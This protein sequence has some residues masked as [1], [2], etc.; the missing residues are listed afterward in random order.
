MVALV[1][2]GDAGDGPEFAQDS[3]SV[4][5]C[6]SSPGEVS[7]SVT[8]SNPDGTQTCQGRYRYDSAVTCSYTNDP[9]CGACTLWNSCADVVAKTDITNYYDEFEFCFYD[10]EFRRVLC[11][12][13]LNAA[14]TWCEGKRSARVSY[15]NG[16]S[17]KTVTS[18]S[19]SLTLMS[20]SPPEYRCRV[21]VNYNQTTYSRREEC[22]CET[23]P[24]CDLMCG[25]QQRYSAPGLSGDEVVALPDALDPATF[26]PAD[27]P[28]YAG[29]AAEIACTTGE[30]IPDTEFQS[31]FGVVY[32]AFSDP[33]IATPDVEDIYVRQ[34]KLLAEYGALDANDY[35]LARELFRDY[36]GVEPVCGD[37]FTD[38]EP[39]CDPDLTWRYSMCARLSGAHVSDQWAQA[40]QDACVRDFIRR[41]ETHLGDAV[42]PA[43][44]FVDS[45]YIMHRA[46][47]EGSS[48]RVLDAGYDTD[49]AGWISTAGAA[50][51]ALHHDWY[52][53]L[54]DLDQSGLPEPVIEHARL[55][56]ELTNN[57]ATFWHHA[58]DAAALDVARDQALSTGDQQAL[59]QALVSRDGLGVELD[60]RVLEAA[61]ATVSIPSETSASV[62]PAATIP[63]GIELEVPVQISDVGSIRG[64]VVSVD[65]DDDRQSDLRV[66][67]RHPS[68]KIVTLHQL[69][70]GPESTLQATYIVHGYDGTASAGSWSLLVRDEVL[71]KG[72][73]DGLLSSFTLEVTGTELGRPVA[74]ETFLAV[75]G[76]S[77]AATIDRMHGLNTYHDFACAVEDCVANPPASKLATL[78]RAMSTLDE[79]QSLASISSGMTD[80]GFSEWGATLGVVAQDDYVNAQLSALANDELGMPYQDALDGPADAWPAPVRRVV[81]ALRTAKEHIANFDGS[82]QFSGDN[83]Q[84][85]QTAVHVS[86][87]T[88]I[89][90][91][92][93][94]KAFGAAGLDNRNQ[95]Y[96]SDILA[97]VDRVVQDLGADTNLTAALDREQA[98]A[99]EYDD[100]AARRAAHVVAAGDAGNHEA[101]LLAALESVDGV[102]D[103]TSYFQVSSVAGSPLLLSGA[104][105]AWTPGAG[106]ITSFAASGAIAVDKDMLLSL[107]TSGTWA[108][109]CSLAAVQTLTPD[110]SSFGP[111]SFPISGGVPNPETGPE[112][113]ALQAAGNSFQAYNY[114]STETSTDT[115]SV[116]FQVC[117]GGGMFGISAQACAGYGHQWS[118][119]DSSS[120]SS[121][122][123]ARLSATFSGGL[124]LANTPFPVGAVGSL[125]AVELP[126]GATDLSQVRDV[127]LVRTGNTVVRVA[128]DSDV[129]LVVNDMACNDQD[130][131]HQLNVVGAILA[132]EHDIAKNMLGRI[133]YT[134]LEVASYRDQLVSTR[135]ILSTELGAIRS[136]ALL[137]VISSEATG[138]PANDNVCFPQVPVS[139]YPEALRVIFD[140]FLDKE[141]LRL[142]RA[143]RIANID[144]ELRILRDQLATVSAEIVNAERT[145]ALITLL[146]SWHMRSLREDYLR[147][148]AL[149]LTRAIQ[150]YFLPVFSLW[151]PQSLSNLRVNNTSTLDNLTGVDLN[152]SLNVAVDD[153]LD[154]TVVLLD[155]YDDAAINGDSSNPEL[156]NVIVSLNAAPPDC[157]PLFCDPAG[158]TVN[159]RRL[160][161][162]IT[163]PIWDTLELGGGV[164]LPIGPDDIYQDGSASGQIACNRQMPVLHHM[165]LMV[166]TPFPYT[167]QDRKLNGQYNGREQTF[168]TQD[169]PSSYT[170]IN[171]AWLPFDMPVLYVSDESS[172]ESVFNSLINSPTAPGVIGLSPFTSFQMREIDSAKWT[173]WGLD[174]AEELFLVMRV[175][176]VRSSVLDPDWISSC[177]SG[178]P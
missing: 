155:A 51:S 28:K 1:G 122:H 79:H 100:L 24:S 48:R 94:N 84:F 161:T 23:Y 176:S 140:A 59:L 80:P 35:D 88:Q 151:H 168:L 134:L 111:I 74:G 118:W 154:L 136:N 93:Q 32:D 90:D 127:H 145:Q 70:G 11:L 137:D 160:D 87:R 98:L 21:T 115:A 86:K 142:E 101:E 7:E 85:L 138:C 62:T 55:D 37:G 68:G 139:S 110:G 40:Q 53:L 54:H 114:A 150:E 172:I 63:E 119:Q 141:I 22:G 128:D 13:D 36:Q 67:L 19:K 129:Y 109:K 156:R 165:A 174:Q 157:N 12:P 121:G 73:T 30:D 116:N 26:D 166:K 82:G 124:H 175:E 170:L 152:T 60:Q 14:D 173:Q 102:I 46:A 64:V 31:K 147:T 5:A 17:N 65:L 72:D 143:V 52:R 120:E 69:E 3:Q 20:N 146:P 126:R 58:A 144:R 96:E 167:G 18:S 91:Y 15:I 169:G 42:C 38:T 45:M 25:M 76:Q 177:A 33:T 133:R 39:G 34:L 153:V 125:L 92:I 108:P 56:D 162:T 44:D 171:D 130:A 89:R 163:D 47:L 113:Y 105:S 29:R 41:L 4:V 8:W 27:E 178:T 10:P 49:R 2:C 123:D 112:G 75:L 107:N 149:D 159:F 132:S 66:G 106:D 117:A 97:I 50:L 78:W 131:T 83:G 71:G 61:V 77:V 103:G 57:L 16:Q 81:T 6:A 164:T 99:D 158:G 148:T 95:E 43:E 104:D 135:D 9:D